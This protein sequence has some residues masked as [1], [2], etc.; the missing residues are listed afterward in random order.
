[1]PEEWMYAE[2]PPLQPRDK[3]PRRHER[4]EKDADLAQPSTVE[5]THEEGANEESTPISAPIVEAEMPV[6]D[7]SV[8]EVV[9]P[10]PTVEAPVTEETPVEKNTEALPEL[11]KDE[12]KD[13]TPVAPKNEV[14]EETK[15]VKDEKPA[16]QKS[17]PAAKAQKSVRPE[18][19]PR[20]KPRGPKPPQR[21]EKLPPKGPRSNKPVAQ[22]FARTQADGPR[23]GSE[24]HHAA[25]ITARPIYTPGHRGPISEEWTPG[26]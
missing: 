21:K 2:L 9:A 17:K 19:E 8:T 13:E 4:S 16:P 22:R 23:D 7:S 25:P 26:Q 20:F 10:T 15:E 3:K 18:R 11:P 12:V 1:M 6:E 5:I 14:K 24:S